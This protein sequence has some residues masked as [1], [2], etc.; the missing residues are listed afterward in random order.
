M[1]ITLDGDSGIPFCQA[2]SEFCN[3]SLALLNEY[4]INLNNCMITYNAFHV[5]SQ[6]DHA[7]Q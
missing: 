4:P 5:F 3:Q 6:F 1:G 7:S 2:N